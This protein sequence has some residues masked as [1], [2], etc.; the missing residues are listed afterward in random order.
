MCVTARTFYPHSA[1]S[2]SVRFAEGQKTVIR[3]DDLIRQSYC[4]LT[5]ARLL[6][7]VNPLRQPGERQPPQTTEPQ[8]DKEIDHETRFHDHRRSRTWPFRPAVCR[9]AA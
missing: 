6:L 1:Q 8:N 4:D 2:S 9:L 3:Q 5:V 7:K